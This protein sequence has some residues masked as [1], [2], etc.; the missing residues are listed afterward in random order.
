MIVHSANS[1]LLVDL[2]E[3]NL[4]HPDFGP[5]SAAESAQ[6]PGEYIYYLG[7]ERAFICIDDEWLDAKYY[8]DLKRMSARTALHP[9]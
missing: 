6:S 9:L 5:P 7:P 3:Y 4:H 1:L 2:A 8:R